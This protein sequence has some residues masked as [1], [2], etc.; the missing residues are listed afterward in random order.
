MN[1]IERIVEK[2]LDLRRLESDPSPSST[3][4]PL[5]LQSE[6]STRAEE[7]SAG[8]HAGWVT[9]LKLETSDGAGF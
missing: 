5:R 4:T 3:A 8:R 2:F 9:T 1:V 7:L 6:I